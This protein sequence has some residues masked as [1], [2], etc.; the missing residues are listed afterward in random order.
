MKVFKEFL[1]KENFRFEESS[2][3]LHFSYQGANFAIAN[4]EKDPLYLQLVM[5]GIYEVNND[6][7]K[8]FEAMNRINGDKKAVKAF[9]VEDSVWMNI[10]MFI[11]STPDLGDFFFRILDILHNA[12]QSFYSNMRE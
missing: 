7:I 4:N 6:K 12:R 9:L 1:Q 5:P 10:E 2:Y 11:D 3:G 8:V